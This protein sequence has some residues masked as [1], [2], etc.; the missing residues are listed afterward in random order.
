MKLRAVLGALG[1][2]RETSD[3]RGRLR[4]LRAFVEELV[5]GRRPR[6]GHLPGIALHA[7]GARPAPTTGCG[8]ACCSTSGRRASSRSAWRRTSRRPVAVLGDVRDGGGRASRR[9]SSRRTWRACRSRALTA[10]RPAELRDRGAPQT[11]DQVRSYGRHAKWSAEVP[12]L[13]GAPETL[14]HWRWLAWPGRRGGGRTGPR[15]GAPQR[16]VPRAAAPDRAAGPAAGARARPRSRPRRPACAGRP[17]LDDL[18]ALAA[19][20]PRRRRA[21]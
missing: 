10:D 9:R 21:G 14:A 19:G 4:G 20:S 5:A 12:L 11:I 13:D 16:A 3:E 18:D 15:A 8:S 7:A 2:S 6:G 17:T 1:R